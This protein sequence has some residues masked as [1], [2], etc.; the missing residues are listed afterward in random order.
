MRA[1]TLWV[2]VVGVAGVVPA[3]SVDAGLAAPPG[4]GDAPA[5]TIRVDANNAFTIERGGLT[6]HGIFLKPAGKGP[7]PAILISHGLGGNARGFG[8]PRAREFVKLGYACIAPDYTHAERNADRKT[9]GAS[10]ENVRRATACLDALAAMSDVDARRVYAYGNSMGAFLTIGLAADCPD[11]LAAA[12]ITAGGVAG[13]QGAAAPST[14][15]AEKIRTPFL[16]L[17]GS[18]DTTVPPE[19]SKTLA[20]ILERNHVPHVRKVFEGINHDLS[21]VKSADVIA[22]IDEWFRKFPAKD[23]KAKGKVR[24]QP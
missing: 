16:I 9:F 13:M 19:R 14:A 18:A 8:L 7:F 12:A 24:S 5:P 22:A 2:F 11:R 15:R 17:H 4:G 6:V 21:T 23:E 3:P 10:E 1:F 20:D